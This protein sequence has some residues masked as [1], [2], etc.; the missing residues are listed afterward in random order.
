MTQQ[1]DIILCIDA[2]KT[3]QN[4]KKNN[5]P[6]IS[7][8]ISELGMI[9]LAS[10]LPEQYKSRK[11]GRLIDLCIIIPSLL[12]S[13]HAFGYLPYDMITNT[14]HRSYFLDLQIQE[15]F[16]QTPDEATPIHTRK[17]KTNIPKRKEKY[18]ND[19]TKKFQNLNLT[20][21]AINLQQEANLQGTW[22]QDL[23]RKYD[24]IDSQATH[25]MLKSEKKC[26]PTYPTIRAWS[27]TMRDL[28]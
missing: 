14:D 28:G 17:L 20:Q 4:Q 16:A 22:N 1:E 24:D 21:A 10:T 3:T 11:I 5:T 9:N 8:L 25:A 2:N 23:Q 15:L 27:G 12:S 18:I 19:I 13:I 7:S 26:S 6:S